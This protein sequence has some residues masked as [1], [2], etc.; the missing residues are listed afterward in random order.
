MHERKAAMAAASEGF[1]ALPGG[2]GTLDEL[3]EAVTWR[4]LGYHDKPV[5]LCDPF[6]YY[7]SLIAFVAKAEAESFVTP[8]TRESLIVT[9]S[10]AE[11]EAT[12]DANVVE[13]KRIG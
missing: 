9:R 7:D 1:I 3:F 13:R 10:I 4:Q 2:F 11:L 12:L 5:M 8:A 6:G